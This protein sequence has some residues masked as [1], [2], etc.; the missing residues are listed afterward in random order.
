MD[1]TG[2]SEQPAEIAERTPPKLADEFSV[3]ECRASYD[4]GGSFVGERKIERN[5]QS[6]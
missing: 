1:G 5:S 2:E 4:A 6:P 3:H